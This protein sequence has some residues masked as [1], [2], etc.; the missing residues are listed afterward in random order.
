MGAV[1]GTEEKQSGLVVLLESTISYSMYPQH[2]TSCHTR[3]DLS[4]LTPQIDK[5]E[6]QGVLGPSSSIRSTCLDTSQC[7]SAVIRLQSGSRFR[8]ADTGRRVGLIGLCSAVGVAGA[9]VRKHL[10]NRRSHAPLNVFHFLLL[11]VVCTARRKCKSKLPK[12]A[13]QGELQCPASLDP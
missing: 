11:A 4:S 8:F 2:R 12:L 10:R 7:L 3:S 5:A 13:M 1:R 6:A 9:A